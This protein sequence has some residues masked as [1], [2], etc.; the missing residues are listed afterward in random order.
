MTKEQYNKAK[1]T[2]ELLERVDLDIQE[3]KYVQKLCTHLTAKD[4]HGNPWTIPA[5]HERINDFL[6]I[7]MQDLVT[8]KA[9]L[10][11]ELSE[12]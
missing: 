7:V 2:M 6:E 4:K 5:S 3:M 12:I 10:E 1:V 8:R 11:K 9:K